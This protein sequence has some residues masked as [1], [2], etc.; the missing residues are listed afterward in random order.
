MGFKYSIGIPAFKAKYFK[1]CIDSVL[2]QSYTNFE[3]IIVNDA[4][5][6]DLDIIISTY[7]DERIIYHKNEKNFGAE[8]VIDNWNK[9]LSYASGDYFILMGDDDKMSQRYLECFDDLIRSNPG[10][11]VYHC[12]SL[13]IDSDSN[14][15]K[16][17]QSWPVYETV[18]ENMWHRI[19]GWRT[20]FISDFVYNKNFLDERNG[21]YKN[22]LAWASDDISSYIAMGNKGIIH[23]NEPLLHY[24]RSSINITSS[25]SAEL[26]LEAVFNEFDWYKCFLAKHAPN[27]DNDEYL[28]ADLKSNLERLK[29]KKII[30]TIAYSGYQSN[31]SWSYNLKYWYDRRKKNGLTSKEIFYAMILAYKKTKAA[32]YY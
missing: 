24:R 7:N 17:T 11:N 1:E 3:L 18:I 13:I 16:L 10:F 8:N 20:Q 29:K 9:C 5:P 23:T 32:G 22:K 27:A 26:K 2:S 30:E 28:L 6:E 15:T 25:G 31:K 4:S 12:R 14:P 19:N 21:F